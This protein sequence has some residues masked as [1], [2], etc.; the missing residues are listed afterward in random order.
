MRCTFRS[1]RRTVDGPCKH[2]VSTT[3]AVFIEA[4]EASPRAAAHAAT[5]GDAPHRWLVRRLKR[6]RIGRRRFGDVAERSK[7]AVL[8]TAEGAT[9]P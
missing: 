1:L 5:L 7:A 4:K 2:P 6:R 8:K 9:P 3:A